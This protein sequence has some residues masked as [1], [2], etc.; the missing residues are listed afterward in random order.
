MHS[1]KEKLKTIEDIYMNE[2]EYA[3]AYS[4]LYTRNF[5]NSVDYKSELGQRVFKHLMEIV[6]PGNEYVVMDA[7]GIEKTKQAMADYSLNQESVASK[8]NIEEKSTEDTSFD[9][10]NETEENQDVSSQF[11][12]DIHALKTK[13][14]VAFTKAQAYGQWRDIKVQFADRAE[15]IFENSKSNFKNNLDILVD[16]VGFNE[17]EKEYLCFS[18][19]YTLD[20]DFR[21]FVNEFSAGH[22]ANYRKVIS[23]MT[24]IDEDKL[25]PLLEKKSRIFRSGL[26]VSPS[27]EAPEGESEES[28]KIRLSFRWPVLHDNLIDN[29]GSLNEDNIERVANLLTGEKTYTNLSWSKD[30]AHLGV[31]NGYIADFFE[32]AVRHD[33]KGNNLLFIGGEGLGKKEAAI[34]LAKERNVELFLVGEDADA[35]LSRNERIDRLQMAFDMLKGRKDCAIL[36]NNAEDILSLYNVSDEGLVAYGRNYLTKALEMN[37][38]PVIFTVSSTDGINKNILA[39]FRGINF[40]IPKAQDRE[41]ILKSICKQQ[42]FKLTPSSIKY[43]SHHFAVASG[44][45]SEAVSSAK[46]IEQNYEDGMPASKRSKIVEEGIK[47]IA[48]SVFGNSKAVEVEDSLSDKYDV[49]LVNAKHNGQPIAELIEEIRESGIKDF[50]MLMY[51]KPGTSKSQTA[52]YIAYKIGVEYKLVGASDILDMYIGNTEKNIARVF[53]EIGLAGDMGLIIDEIDS[54]LQDRSK[55]EKSYEKS[56]VTEL[57]RALDKADFP[58]LFTTN[59]KSDLDI[60]SI[61]R[62]DF[63]IECNYLTKDQRKLAFRKFFKRQAPEALDVLDDLGLGEFATVQRQMRFAKDKSTMNILRKLAYEIDQRNDKHEATLGFGAND[64]SSFV[65]KVEK[66]IIAAKS[67]KPIIA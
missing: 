29:I 16:R 38:V 31:D 23:V 11:N 25:A 65:K 46:L 5:M 26:V 52:K 47:L 45:L 12:P 3:S 13:R 35:E 54:L 50:R 64:N 4:V 67:D 8:E 1:S 44:V 41:K 32:T 49:A 66:A 21:D 37:D 61:R 14:I 28:R 57:L 19:A 18:Y 56:Q 39:K 43:L 55:A 17:E 27:G 34:A 30:F 40:K 7:K 62:I 58:I 63:K 9:A 33:V 22:H 59:T 2:A 60:A 53:K 51:G 36:V 42:D 15:D 48:N 24:G 10:L 20:A 6:A